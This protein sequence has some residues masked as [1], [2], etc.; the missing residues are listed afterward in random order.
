MSANIKE[1][2]TSYYLMNTPYVPYQVDIT[3]GTVIYK[4]W[5]SGDGFGLILRITVAGSVTTYEYCSRA[6]WASRATS[7]YIPLWE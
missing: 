5:F 4:R 7:N 3:D 6:K 1:L 2:E